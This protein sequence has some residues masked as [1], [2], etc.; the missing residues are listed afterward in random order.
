MKHSNTGLHAFGLSLGKE[1][2][3][4]N[5]S[6]YD[7]SC[8]IYG[9]QKGVL[10][11]HIKYLTYRKFHSVLFPSRSRYDVVHFG[12]QCCRLNP[13]LVKAK[14]I[15]TVHD[16]NQVHEAD[17]DSKK[18]RR[19]LDK[20]RAKIDACDQIVTISHFVARDV[21]HYF[22]E[23]K[24]RISVIYN[25]A[26]VSCAPP[27][28][29]PKFQPARPFLFTIGMLCA[30]KNF[31]VLVPLLKN[32]DMQLIVSGIVNADYEQKIRAEAAKFGVAERVIITGTISQQDKDWYYQHCQAFVFP[33]LAEGFG[34]PVIEAMRHGKPVFLSKYTSL[35]EIGGAAAYYFDHFDPAHMVTVFEQGM[36]H[37]GANDGAHA[38]VEHA[39]QFTWEKAAKAYLQ[40]YRQCQAR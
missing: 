29:L 32:N 4:Q 6:A 36:R 21:A 7:L 12:D 38:V 22:P 15:L 2:I 31:H 25:G 10:G 19:H 5:H 26:D 17:S 3:K 28:H 9:A 8:Y 1:L 34:L 20:L 37:F 23:A 16:L 11:S 14:K 18:A 39:K 35:P 13:R 40:L 30:K 27:Q 24:D 33:S